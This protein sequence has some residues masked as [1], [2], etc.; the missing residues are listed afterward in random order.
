M[1]M[2]RCNYDFL[3]GKIAVTNNG[4]TQLVDEINLA[5]VTFVTQKGERVGCKATGALGFIEGTPTAV[6]V[7][8]DKIKFD[9]F[10]FVDKNY[11]DVKAAKLVSIRGKEILAE[12]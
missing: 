8:G 5:D 4:E 12:V 2:V 3:S 6:P 9:G 1:T 11:I 7:K 10:G